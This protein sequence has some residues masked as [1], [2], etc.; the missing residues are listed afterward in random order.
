MTERHA[1]NLAVVLGLTAA[2][3]CSGSA[4]PGPGNTVA[5]P[6]ASVAESG[7]IAARPEDDVA[8]PESTVWSGV[9]S[10][11]QAV[12]GAAEYE[13]ACSSCHSTDLRGNSNAPSLIGVSFL[14]IW[15][16]RSLGELFTAIRTLMP[17][18]APN[19]LPTRSY[20]NIL[21]YIMEANEFPAGSNEL[22]ADPAVLS[23][24][25]ITAAPGQ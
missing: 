10:V 8:E 11:E 25:L 23:Q 18:N 14:F 7:N 6:A 24:I 15:E 17:T 5:G 3:A 9:Y 1:F 21:A 4:G 2:T 16:D 19:S 22:G 13:R 20:L 12:R